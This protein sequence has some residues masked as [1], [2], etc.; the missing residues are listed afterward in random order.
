MRVC[1]GAANQS[2]WAYFTLFA[3]PFAGVFLPHGLGHLIGGDTHDVGGYLAGTPARIMAPGLR[4]LRTARVLEAG[5]ESLRGSGVGDRQSDGVGGTGQGDGGKGEKASQLLSFDV[6]IR[7]P[8]CS[9]SLS[10]VTRP[11]LTVPFSRESC[12]QLLNCITSWIA[13]N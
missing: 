7:I 5:E 9:D 2:D 8:P 12:N 4:K 6:Y 13:M 1:V 3:G 11:L 10:L